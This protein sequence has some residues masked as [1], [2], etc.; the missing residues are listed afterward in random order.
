M[1][2]V[3]GDPRRGC[4]RRQV[5]RHRRAGSF[6]EGDRPD[7]HRGLGVEVSKGKR[8]CVRGFLCVYMECMGY[9]V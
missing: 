3:A 2:C 7:G 5:H 1:I 6:D 9:L 4:G 8:E